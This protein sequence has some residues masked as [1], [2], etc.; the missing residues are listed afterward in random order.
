[1]Y[2]RRPSAALVPSRASL[3][4]TS[5]VELKLR[6]SNTI[7]LPASVAPTLKYH[8]GNIARKLT[9]SFFQI[10]SLLYIRNRKKDLRLFCVLRKQ[11]VRPE[12]AFTTDRTPV[13]V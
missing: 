3:P 13:A 1:M 4:R 7:P 8:I 12:H 2:R 5:W 11:I 6:D 9:S 10:Y